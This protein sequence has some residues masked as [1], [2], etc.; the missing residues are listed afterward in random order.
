MWTIM[1]LLQ[2]Q[3][4]RLPFYLQYWIL[5]LSLE[6]SAK[7]RDA[8]GDFISTTHQQLGVWVWSSVVTGAGVPFQ[9][10]NS[11]IKF[12][13]LGLLAFDNAR[14][15]Y[16]TEYVCMYVCIC[17]FVCVCIMYVCMCVC[18]YVCVC[19]HA[20]MCVYACMY[21]CVCVY[22]RMC[23]CMCVWIYVYVYM[24]VRTYV[25]VCVC[26]YVCM[27]MYLCMY[28]CVCMYVRVCVCVCMDVCV[29]MHVCT[30][31]YFLYGI[32]Y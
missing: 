15:S 20:C 28:V 12:K 7:W 17:M 13:G 26:M 1:V 27:C 2:Q 21:V 11:C 19:M 3:T 18:V 30:Y 5:K 24:Y 25:F 8:L 23:V 32:I 16:L 22:V 14:F 10:E 9:Y 29:C 6:E 31:V 4:A